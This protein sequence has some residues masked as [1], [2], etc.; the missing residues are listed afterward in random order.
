MKIKTLFTAIAALFS[1]SLIAREPLAVG[2][3][4]PVIEVTTDTGDT[5]KLSDV[6]A[7]GFTLVYFYPKADT[8]GCTKQACSLRD[9]YASLQDAGVTILGVSMDTVEDQ[10][11]FKEKYGLPFT[12]IADKAGDLVK[13]FGVPARGQ[14]A[15]R[16]AFLIK[17]GSVVW[18]DLKASTA[19]QAQD[20][21]AA[22]AQL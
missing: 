15:S 21:Q 3:S 16:Q 17:K 9:A 1:T 22:L 4:A 18:R 10:A 6:Y 8:P 11:A 5:L 13:A 20:V 14:F 12:L 7:A 2:E 19:K